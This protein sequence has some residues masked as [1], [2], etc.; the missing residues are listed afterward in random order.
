[1]DSSKRNR[2]AGKHPSYKKRKMTKE[3][4]AK[5]RD[6]QKKY[7]QTDSAKKHRSELNKENRNRGTYGNGDGKDISHSSDGKSVKQESQSKNRARKTGVKQSRAPR[8]G[9]GK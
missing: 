9:K 1:M 2:F 3:Q 5:K 4:I 7:N 8:R 6:Y